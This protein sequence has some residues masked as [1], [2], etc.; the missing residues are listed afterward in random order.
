MN[1]TA[2][3]PW[4]V[5]DSL[6]G[7]RGTPRLDPAPPVPPRDHAPA[8][9]EAIAP[10]CVNGPY[11]TLHRDLLRLYH[12]TRQVARRGR[13]LIG[14][15]GAPKDTWRTLLHVYARL[16]GLQEQLLSIIR[17]VERLRDPFPERL[18]QPPP[19]PPALPAVEQAPSA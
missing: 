19:H 3:A 12:H 4:C 17:Q 1:R 15:E 10:K 7:A 11:A 13:S 9:A 2:H 16:D 8:F 5:S 18:E 6:L 14:Q